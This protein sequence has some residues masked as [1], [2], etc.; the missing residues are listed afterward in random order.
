MLKRRD[1]LKLSAAGMSKHEIAASLGVSVTAAR[2]VH[3]AGAGPRASPGRCRGPHGRGAGGYEARP[4]GSGQHR[5]R[6]FCFLG[7][8]LAG[9]KNARGA[10]RTKEWAIRLMIGERR[11]ATGTFSKGQSCTWGS[12]RG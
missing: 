12:I 8:Q 2:G 1:V 4:S 11:E 6:S 3:L 10:G 7:R 9:Q 5:Q